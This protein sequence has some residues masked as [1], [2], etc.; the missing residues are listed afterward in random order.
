MRD[1]GMSTTTA[2][3]SRPGIMMMRDGVGKSWSVGDWELWE[4]AAGPWKESL[5]RSQSKSI[6]AWAA[7]VS[8]SS[9]MISSLLVMLRI[10]CGGT[11]STSLLWCGAGSDVASRSWLC[12]RLSSRQMISLAL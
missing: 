3:P 8:M 2:G 4:D 1:V 5:G 9:R 11:V 10:T 6:A 7:T 12:G